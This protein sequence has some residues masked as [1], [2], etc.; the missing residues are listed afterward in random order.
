MNDQSITSK[1]L[2]I[3]IGALIA[4]L[5]VG[6]QL[7]L[8]IEN[9]VM[10]IPMT[11]IQFLSFFTI[12]TNILVGVYFTY[13]GV[14]PTSTPGL[15]FASPQ[16]STAITVYIVV[17]GL[18][19]NIILR[20]IWNPQ[21]LQKIVDEAL[22]SIIPLY[23][24][25]YWLIYVP[26]KTLSFR[27]VPAWLLYPLVYILYILIRGS[28]SGLYPYPFVDVNKLGYGQ[29]LQNSVFLTM[30]FLFLSLGFVGLGKLLSP[31]A[32]A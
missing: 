18:V 22:H 30:L 20:S 12:L 8:I 3:T 16:V 28:L 4:W 26:K 19:Y 27:D 2:F 13:C 1:R 17:V 14:K 6:L 11:I 10:S 21:G 7:Y 31:K 23:F 32:N 25:L 15:F 9:R 5:A 29:V 24:L